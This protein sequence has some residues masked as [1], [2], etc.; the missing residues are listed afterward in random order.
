MRIDP[1][2][3]RSPATGALRPVTEDLLAE[4]YL[5]PRRPELNLGDH[6]GSGAPWSDSF[7][8]APDETAQA[9]EAG[10]LALAEAVF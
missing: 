9:V 1:L 2:I 8:A 10:L 4:V 6:L 7:T 3:T 5:A